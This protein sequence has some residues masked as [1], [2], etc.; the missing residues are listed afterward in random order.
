MIDLLSQPIN[1]KSQ[2]DNKESKNSSIDIVRSMIDLLTQPINKKSQ[3]DKKESK[4][5][6]I[7]I[8]RSMIDLLSQPINK[9]SQIDQKEPKNN[10][11]KV[12]LSQ[13][14]DV[15]SEIDKKNI[16]QAEL[17]KKFP[18][19]YQFCNKDFNKFALLLT[20][21]IYP[22]EYIDSWEK[23]DE[24]PSS[25]EDKRIFYSALNNE[26]ITEEDHAH[27]LKVQDTFKIKNLGEYYDLYVQSDTLLLADEINA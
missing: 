27:A 16:S 6:S 22:Y 24:Q 11:M 17:I 5:N 18:N 19:I 15:V 1:K 8:V 20:K 13:S 10:Y 14:T 12:L 7:D 9:K 21:G 2:I 23:F 25:L 3:I 4:N 26:H